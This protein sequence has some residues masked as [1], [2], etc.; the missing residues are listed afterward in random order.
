MG[1]TARSREDIAVEWLLSN[2]L[3]PDKFAEMYPLKK[4]ST[5]KTPEPGVLYRSEG[6][7]RIPGTY[8]QFTGFNDIPFFDWDWPDPRHPVEAVTI[9]NM[10]DAVSAVA[11]YASSYPDSR[12][13]M[14]VTPGGMHAAEITKRASPAEIYSNQNILSMSPDPYYRDISLRKNRFDIRTSPKIGRENDFVGWYMG[15]IG[16]GLPDPGMQQQ[17]YKHYDRRMAQFRNAQG[18]PA[19]GLA[20]QSQQLIQEQLATVPRSILRSW[21]RTNFSAL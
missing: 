10:G 18:M 17:V 8:I 7:P 16:T 3:P 14:Y 12:F 2:P 11:D 1:V 20:P 15:D 21:G 6:Y 9:R 4:Q 19:Y 5:S 13:R